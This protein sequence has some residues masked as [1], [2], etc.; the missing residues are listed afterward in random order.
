[1]KLQVGRRTGHISDDTNSHFM[2]KPLKFGLVM[3]APLDQESPGSSPGGAMKESAGTY[4]LPTLCLTAPLII[5]SVCFSRRCN[6]RC[7]HGHLPP[8][9]GFTGYGKNVCVFGVVVTSEHSADCHPTL[10]HARQ[11]L[12]PGRRHSSGHGKA[13]S[14]VLGHRG[15]R[16]LTAASHVPLMFS[17]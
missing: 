17:L 2:S 6:V 13:V 8:L 7:R 16:R 4:A 12:E 3:A 15:A 10:R 9:A 1:M 11:H 14:R 5:F